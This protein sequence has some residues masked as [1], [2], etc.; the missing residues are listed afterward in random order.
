[1]TLLITYNFLEPIALIPAILGIVLNIIYEY[2]KGHGIFGNIV[3][4]LMISMCTAFGFLAS[5]PTE[6]PY[7]TSS[8]VSVLI[9]VAV[10]NGLMTF[11]TYFKIS[12][13]IRLQINGR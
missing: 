10:M 9:L 12:K 3:F 5:G 7:F 2:A 13:G 1:M 11:Y 6:F 4:G 8:R